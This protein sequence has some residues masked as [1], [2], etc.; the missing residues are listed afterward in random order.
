MAIRIRTINGV[1]IALCAAK[2]E[3]KEGDLYLDDSIHH[4]LSTK[5]GL[6]WYSE[7]FLEKPMDDELLTQLMVIEG[8]SQPV[9]ARVIS[10]LAEDFE[11]VNLNKEWDTLIAT[12][13][14][15]RYKNKEREKPVII[16]R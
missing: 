9:E 8:D 4:A 13:L 16:E 1:T 6:D 5:F 11:D 10:F 14:L 2:T 3:A 15:K 7:G 12:I